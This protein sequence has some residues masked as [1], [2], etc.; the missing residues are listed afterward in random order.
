M[1]K[2]D[3]LTVLLSFLPVVGAQSIGLTGWGD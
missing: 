2:P 1:K 3:A